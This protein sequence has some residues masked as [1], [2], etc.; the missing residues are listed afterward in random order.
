MN[1][2]H[3]TGNK[4]KNKHFRNGKRKDKIE[5]LKISSNSNRHQRS[6]DDGNHIL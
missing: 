6:E 2:Q 4:N 3:N 1:D 5:H